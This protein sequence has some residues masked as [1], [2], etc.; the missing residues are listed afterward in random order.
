MQGEHLFLRLGTVH[1][2]QIGV[3]R[4]EHAGPN[5]DRG[6]GEKGIG[7][8]L[9]AIGQLHAANVVVLRCAEHARS[10]IGIG[11]VFACLRQDNALAIKARLLDVYQTVKRCVFFAG[12]T[13]AGIEHRVEGFARMIGKTRSTG[14]LLCAQPIVQ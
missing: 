8:R 14:E 7:C 6:A 9:N 13:L 3:A 1:H 4:G 5:T 10:G 12:Y 2:Q 11:R